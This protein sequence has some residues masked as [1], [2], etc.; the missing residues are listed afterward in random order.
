MVVVKALAYPEEEHVE[1]EAAVA[2][3]NFVEL[4]EDPFL[5]VAVVFVAE[6]VEP[7]WLGNEK[8]LLMGEQHSIAQDGIVMELPWRTRDGQWLMVV[9]LVLQSVEMTL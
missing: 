5:E 1:V 8:P 7:A 6:E 4:V 2:P 3:W 9:R